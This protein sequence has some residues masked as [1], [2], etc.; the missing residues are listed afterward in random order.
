MPPS[1]SAPLVHTSTRCWQADRHIRGFPPQRSGRSLWRRRGRCS[2]RQR[3]DWRCWSRSPKRLSVAG[4]GRPEIDAKA[5]P[6]VLHESVGGALLH[7]LPRCFC[8][9][10][11]SI[12][13]TQYRTRTQYGTRTLQINKRS[14]KGLVYLA[15]WQR[16]ARRPSSALPPRGLG[17]LAPSALNRRMRRPR[18]RLRKPATTL[19]RVPSGIAAASG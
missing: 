15:P 13:A 9:V 4:I 6:A 1:P 14:L 3:D 8:S 19:G 2:N 10:A 16:G 17:G 11:D 7:A 12:P 5:N 18:R